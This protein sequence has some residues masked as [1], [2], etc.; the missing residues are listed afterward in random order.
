[1]PCSEED[2][3]ATE[4]ESCDYTDMELAQHLRP[5]EFELY[6]S[7]RKQWLQEAVLQEAHT[8]QAEALQEEMEQLQRCRICYTKEANAILMD[9]GHSGVCLDC[10]PRLRSRACPFC[11]RPVRDIKQVFMP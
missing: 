5:A 1:M 11:R 9:C 8:Q 6:M 10:A 4:C 3:A 7:R 2:T